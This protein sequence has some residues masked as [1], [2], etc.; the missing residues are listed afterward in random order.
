[1]STGR[2]TPA[3]AHV[4]VRILVVVVLVVLALTML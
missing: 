1:V 4:T 2:Q 3:A